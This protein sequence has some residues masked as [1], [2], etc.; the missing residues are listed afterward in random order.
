MAQRMTSRLLMPL[1]EWLA[2]AV[3]HWSLIVLLGG[4]IIVLIAILAA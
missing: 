3:D 1:A 2:Q 4:Y